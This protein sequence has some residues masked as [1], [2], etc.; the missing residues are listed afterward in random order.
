M[1]RERKGKP[2]PDVFL[3]I[4]G[5]LGRAPQKEWLANKEGVIGQQSVPGTKRPVLQLNPKR[6]LACPDLP[7]VS[8]KAFS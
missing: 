5:Q 8:S 7:W 4:P 2:Q 1:G 6:H 3:K